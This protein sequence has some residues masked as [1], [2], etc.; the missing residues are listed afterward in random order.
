MRPWK[1]GYSSMPSSSSGPCNA[2]PQGLYVGSSAL[3]RQAS[4]TRRLQTV[5]SE[6]SS[7]WFLERSHQAASA[8]T[9]DD[10]S[11]L[12]ATEDPLTIENQC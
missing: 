4:H 10:F 11:P 3:V 9:N 12:A 6:T 5:A 8:K 2:A 7:V 1:S